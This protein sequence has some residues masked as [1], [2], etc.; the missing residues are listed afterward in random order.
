MD[1]LVDFE[2]KMKN[3]CKMY[4]EDYVIHTSEEKDRSNDNIIKIIQEELNLQNVET[5]NILV[6]NIIR[7]NEV[8]NDTNDKVV[9]ELKQSNYPLTF[10]GEPINFKEATNV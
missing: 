2:L 7:S 9:E 3:G 6:L 5:I 10:K 4:A 8:S 1:I